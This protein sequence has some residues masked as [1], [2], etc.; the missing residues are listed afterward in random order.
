MTPPTYDSADRLGPRPQVL[1]RGAKSVMAVAL[2]AVLLAACQAA[3]TKAT[4]LAAASAP[5]CK[6]PSW[7]LWDEFSKHFI[8]ADGRVLD[9]ST[10][11]QHSSSEGQSYAM[12]FALVAGDA[13]TFDRLWRWTVDNLAG[14]NIEQN[15]P[16]WHWGRNADNNW[17]VLDR[18]SASDA[19]LWFAYSLLEA[20]DRWKRADYT[21]DAKTLLAAVEAK[22][23]ADL[24]GLGKMLLPGHSDF[25]LPENTWQLNPS[26]MPLPLLRRLAIASPQGPWSKI[27]NNT[28]VMLQTVSPKGFVADWVSYRGA[29][30]N[31]TFIV[32]ARKGDLGSY[33][34]IR[35]Y[36]WAGLTPSGDPLAAP[37]LNALHGMASATAD[38]GIPPEKVRTTTGQTSGSGPFGFSAALVPYFQARGQ[39]ELANAQQKRAQTLLEQ[40]LLPSQ[41]QQKQPPYYDFVLSLFGLGW[42]DKHYRFLRTGKVQLS[43]ETTCLRATTP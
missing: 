20:G 10:P 16:A 23:V 18:N 42:A 41:L 40:S 12:F 38:T 25:I 2:M 34:A 13:A 7:T 8:Q 27:A 24:P 28:A 37:V 1:R 31:G 36:L 30:A 5:V 39:H 29:N 3:P 22:E 19:D 11:Q 9:A 17:G 14:G 43:W 35:T 4:T 6:V 33:D 32:D 21:R 15:L 26:Y